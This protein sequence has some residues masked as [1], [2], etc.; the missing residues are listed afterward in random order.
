[1]YIDVGIGEIPQLS[2]G[3]I[4][5][6]V[7]RKEQEGEGVAQYSLSSALFI[8]ATNKTRNRL[9]SITHAKPTRWGGDNRL[10]EQALCIPSTRTATAIMTLFLT[11]Y[12]ALHSTTDTHLH[13]HLLHHPHYFTT[14]DK[15]SLIN[16]ISELQACGAAE[17]TD[18]DWGEQ[19][20]SFQSAHLSSINDYWLNL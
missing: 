17:S 8:L 1:V 13:L 11:G 14:L 7:K 19:H 5:D 2:S 18:I 20:H 6:E 10:S 12:A 3:D 15:L 9:M 4:V 16:Q